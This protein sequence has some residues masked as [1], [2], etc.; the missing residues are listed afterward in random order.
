VDTRYAFSKSACPIPH[1]L[2]LSKL[3]SFCIKKAEYIDVN[4]LLAS[5]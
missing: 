1:G 3:G 2:D 4:S 5:D